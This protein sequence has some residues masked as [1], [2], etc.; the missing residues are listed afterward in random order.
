MPETFTDHVERNRREWNR[1]AENWV[2]R[3]RRDWAQ[4][5]I[6]W[7][8]LH[9]REGE[10]D[11]LGEVSGWDVL[12]LGCG[13]A[14]FS[15][16]LARRGAKVIGLDVSE[17]QLETARRLQGE[18]KVDFPLIQANAEQV[19]FDDGGFDLILSEYGAS[20]WADPYVWVPEAA[21]L[22]RPGGGLVFLVNSALLMLC[23][24][25][26]DKVV[27]AV[28]RL[29]RPYFGMH[30]FEWQSDDSVCFNLAH[31]EWLR[32][33]RAS[34]FEVEALVELQ[35]P[36]DVAPDSFG[37]ASKA[38]AR[39]WPAEDIWKARKRSAVGRA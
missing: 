15:S 39:Q 19:P 25:D 36:A 26:E 37:L 31:G 3:G 11:L 14:Y 18:F 29:L 24:P 33:L 12:E 7:G 8:D 35:A 20:I 9:V 21:R 13:T 17:R 10:L 32:L 34:G 28:E 38:W 22:L 1:W 16:W 27:P 6:T 23:M 30:R 5:E 4:D 2:E